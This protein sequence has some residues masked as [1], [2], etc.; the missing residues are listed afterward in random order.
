MNLHS[1]RVVKGLYYMAKKTCMMFT[2]VMTYDSLV[3][4]KTGKNDQDSRCD[5]TLIVSLKDRNNTV[6]IV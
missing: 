6:E 3:W 5:S 1:T 4:L 2:I